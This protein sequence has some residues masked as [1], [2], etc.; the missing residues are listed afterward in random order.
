MYDGLTFDDL[1]KFALD[2]SL[3]ENEKMGFAER[4]RV[5]SE[6]AIFRD[7][8]SK[9]PALAGEGR[10]V[11][12]IGC[13]CGSLVRTLIATCGARRHRLVLVDSPEMLGLVD[14]PAGVELRPH[15]FPLDQS[16]LDEYRG[17]GDAVI[18]YS[19]L[20]VEV[21]SGDVLR[22]VDGLCALLAPGGR[23]LIGDIPNRSMR[24]RLFSS[25]AGK[26]FHRAFTGEN[27]DSPTP[28]PG[29]ALGSIDDAAVLGLAARARAQGFNAF[30]MPQ[31]PDLPFSN[32]REDLLV[33][34]Y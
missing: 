9:L 4:S 5:D 31:A 12:D 19:A 15:R 34:R 24:Q 32:R 28:A 17:T 2:A 3:S 7:F 6:A 20:Q 30:V 27:A 8:Q 16:F 13:G 22:L 10:T 1:R 18:F 33:E 25:E 26:A 14:A 23:A 11:I 21:A 29:L